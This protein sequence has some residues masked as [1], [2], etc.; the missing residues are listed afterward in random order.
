MRL[1]GLMEIFRTISGGEAD[2]YTGFLVVDGYPPLHELVLVPE[3]HSPTD[4]IE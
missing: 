3:D 1:D 4:K 2:T